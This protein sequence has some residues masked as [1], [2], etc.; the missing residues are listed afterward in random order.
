MQTQH[1]IQCGLSSETPGMKTVGWKVLGS[2][3]YSGSVCI[4]WYGLKGVRHIPLEALL[5]SKVTGEDC[6][7]IMQQVIIKFRSLKEI[8]TQFT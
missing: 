3:A 7:S 1:A 8:Y 5:N 2:K 6:G 4:L